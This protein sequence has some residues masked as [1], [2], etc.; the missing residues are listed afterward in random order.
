MVKPEGKGPLGRTIS[1]WEDK[2][3]TDVQEMG[4]WIGLIWLR[5]ATGETP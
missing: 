4:T 2:I 1:R 3:K 5:T